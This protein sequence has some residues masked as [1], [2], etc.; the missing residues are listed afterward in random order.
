[1]ADCY[2]APELC[3]YYCTHE[4]AIGRE[5]VDVVEKKSLSQITVETL[6]ALNKMSRMKDR[7]LEIVEDTSISTDEYDDF[8]IIKSTLDKI[9][10]SISALQLWIDSQVAEGRLDEKKFRK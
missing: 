3:N 8:F 9:S 4:C 7:L 2:K 6:N 5:K 10:V 1:M